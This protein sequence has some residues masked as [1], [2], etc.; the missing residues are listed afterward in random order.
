MYNAVINGDWAPAEKIL[1]RDR[2]LAFEKL[3]K[4]GDRALH[5]SVCRK[6]T[7]FVQQLVNH[8]VDPSKLELLDGRGYSACCYAAKTD[9]VDAAEIMMKKN[10]NLCNIRNKHRTTPLQ[11]AVFY[12]KKKSAM[13][14]L[15][16]AQVHDLS[17]EEWVELLLVSIRS[18]MYGVALE[19]LEK[20]GS[21]AVKK[22][23]DQQITA[24]HVLAQL[25]LSGW[26][27]KDEREMEHDLRNFA[28]KLCA[29]IQKLVKKR[30]VDQQTALHV[31]SQL[32]LSSSEQAE[33]E[34]SDLRNL[35]KKL[36]AEIQKLEKDKVLELIN[37]PPIIHEAAKVGNV[38][39]ITMITRAYPDLLE[40][41]NDEGHSIYHT[42]AMYQQEFMLELINQR[43]NI[44]AY[45]AISEDV[46]GNNLLHLAGKLLPTDWSKIICEPDLQMEKELAWFKKVEKS[47]PPFFAEMRNNSGYRPREVFWKEHKSLA[48]EGGKHLKSTAESGMLV[49]TIILT[50]VFAAAFTPPGGYDQTEGKPILVIRRNRWFSI[51]VVFDILALLSSTYSI[52]NF[53]SILSSEYKEKQVFSSPNHLRQALAA[54]LLSLLCAMSTF[55]AAFFMVARTNTELLA[56]FMIPIYMF[57]V[58]GISF[59]FFRIFPRANLIKHYYSRKERDQKKSR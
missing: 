30:G 19:I 20:D 42:A 36:W 1:S 33:M 6:N 28:E 59:Q 49:S 48:E 25:D 27:I 46:N 35:A 18:K 8:V 43:E 22:G 29:K 3:T 5:L 9:E 32:D 53:W 11:L 12:G 45:N 57:L 58:V 56:A 31:Q 4:T 40:H 37:N 10:P 15:R 23:V 54:L 34:S 44:L 38:E 16:S 47:V 21:L 55:L 39:L 17:E 26:K 41:T 14:F 50:V 13:R 52:L 24:L 7:Q 51:F 2:S